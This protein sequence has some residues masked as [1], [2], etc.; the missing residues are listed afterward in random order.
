[1]SFDTYANLQVEIL[2]KL[3]RASDTDA[4]T[5]CPSWIALA[6]D[7]MRM[8][9]TR[10]MVRQGEAVDNNYTITDEYTDLPSGFFRMRSNPVLTS[11]SPVQILDYVAPTVADKWD[12]YQSAAKP[13]LWTIQNNQLRVSPPPD[14]SYTATLSYFSLPS[15]SASL[16]SNW[17]LAA[18][19]KLYF[20][21]A[22]AEAYDY[23]DDDIARDAAQADR[24][25]MLSAIYT[26][27][28][29]DQQGTRLRI[30]VD[31]RTP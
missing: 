19:P 1:M 21:A 15:L 5:R 17:L 24:D 2:A 26:S 7:E 11:V 25:R 22:L 29:V 4:V 23:Y 10:L 3:N 20:K 30:R 8:A 9:L 12:P 27:D 13:R 18:H 31:G 16:S 14:A 6:E 28:G